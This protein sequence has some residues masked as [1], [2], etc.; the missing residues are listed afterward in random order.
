MPLSFKSFRV[1]IHG[2]QACD[3]EDGRNRGD[4]I[5]SRSGRKTDGGGHPEPGGRSH[6]TD[7]ILLEDDD[8]GADKA[9]A[10][11]DLSRNPGRIVRLIPKRILG[12][13]HK[14]GAAQR[15]HKVRPDA[16]FLCPQLALK[17]DQP[18]QQPGNQ[19]S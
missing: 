19:K 8:A 5:H 18:A 9:D 2:L 1:E 14:Q 12:N 10:R 6:A 16:G 11:D 13:N 3:G 4:A 15:N 7:H 17:T